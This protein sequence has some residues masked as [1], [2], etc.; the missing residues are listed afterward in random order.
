[1]AVNVKPTKK[2]ERSSRTITLKRESKADFDKSFRAEATQTDAKKKYIRNMPVKTFNG[3]TYDRGADQTEGRS[4]N[5]AS[6]TVN[7]GVMSN[8]FGINSPY[9]GS[10]ESGKPIEITEYVDN[11][12]QGDDKIS[13]GIEVDLEGLAHAT[14]EERKKNA[15]QNGATVDER[16]QD[17]LQLNY[18][19]SS[20]KNGVAALNPEI[21]ATN[22]A[23]VGTQRYMLVAS[24]KDP[25][26]EAFTEKDVTALADTFVSE[27]NT[28]LL[29]AADG[30]L[31]SGLTSKKVVDGKVTE[32]PAIKDTEVSKLP[33]GMKLSPI[34][35]DGATVYAVTGVGSKTSELN[36]WLVNF[37][38]YYNAKMSQVVNGTPELA[39]AQGENPITR[40]LGLVAGINSYAVT[41]VNK[42]EDMNYALIQPAT[43]GK[44]NAYAQAVRS[45]HDAATYYESN[46]QEVALETIY[47][48]ERLEVASSL[49]EICRPESTTREA[50]QK[51]AQ[52]MLAKVE[53]QISALDAPAKGKGKAKEEPSVV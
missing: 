45:A 6:I 16:S 35:V 43:T 25:Q 34:E 20:A 37:N 7:F 51:N 41:P 13:Y 33:D 44:I 52:E 50:A 31:T 28:A 22:L 47:G 38:N 48:K 30:K 23:K 46:G 1:M 9:T 8:S 17:R 24:K 36:K 21:M 5:E 49:S 3:E 42:S 53:A 4:S 11:S 14:F 12:R 10:T 2:V 39:G 29:A 40:K 15:E 19:F 26:K 27:Y 32:G 18:S